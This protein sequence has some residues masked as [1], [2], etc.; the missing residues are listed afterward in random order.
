MTLNT[1]RPRRIA[2]RIICALTLGGIL[3]AGLSPFHSPVNQVAWLRGGDGIYI[4][5]R[6]VV[7][8]LDSPEKAAHLKGPCASV[9]KIIWRIMYLLFSDFVF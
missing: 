9:A 3:V 8:N 7:L 5:N 2:L 4:G 1:D 6:G